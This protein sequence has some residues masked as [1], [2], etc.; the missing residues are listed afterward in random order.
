MNAKELGLNGT[1]KKRAMELLAEAKKRSLTAEEQAEIEQYHKLVTDR[2]EQR[3]VER[4]KERGGDTK[5]AK[6]LSAYDRARQLLKAD[7]VKTDQST[8]K[9]S[10]MASLIRSKNPKYKKLGEDIKAEL[11]EKAAKKKPAKAKAPKKARARKAK[12][13][14]ETTTVPETEQQQ[15]A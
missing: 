9:Q 12:T 2:A 15:A 4:A 7:G 3:R 11:Q 8:T 14:P 10:L 1:Q 6:H 5:M 13:A